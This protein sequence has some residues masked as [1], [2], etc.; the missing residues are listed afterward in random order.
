LE[1][2]KYGFENYGNCEEIVESPMGLSMFFF[3]FQVPWRKEEATV[4]ANPRTNFLLPC[5][6]YE[7]TQTW[8]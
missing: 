5:V 4:Y 3:I 7:L 1:L 2:R 8:K 6:Q